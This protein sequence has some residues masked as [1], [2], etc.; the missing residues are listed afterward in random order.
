MGTITVGTPRVKEDIGK[1]ELII[2]PLAF[3]GTYATGGDTLA[4]SDVPS[5]I[6]RIKDIKIEETAAN[7]YL[8]DQA[9]G[10]VLAYVKTTGIE[11]A[12]GVDLTAEA[13][14]ATIWA[15]AD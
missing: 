13:P 15:G 11:V 8:W 3:A 1:S 2:A 9:N 12:N 10:K 14:V 6:E 5:R 7:S 4:A